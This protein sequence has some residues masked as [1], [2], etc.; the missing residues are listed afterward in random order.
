[1]ALKVKDKM[2]E[3]IDEELRAIDARLKDV[4][5][6]TDVLLKEWKDETEAVEEVVEEDA[7]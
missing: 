3:E 2:L 4:L 1:M 7:Q 6:K 5:S